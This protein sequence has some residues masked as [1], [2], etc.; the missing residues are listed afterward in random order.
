[1]ARDWSSSGTLEASKKSS[2]FQP[3]FDSTYADPDEAPD[4]GGEGVFTSKSKMRWKFRGPW[5]AGM[6]EAEL[7]TYI[8]KEVRHRKNDFREYVRAR[9]G[10]AKAHSQDEARREM[11]VHHG[12]SSASENLS[13][14]ELDD[15]IRRLR[16]DL[17]E[18]PL[19]IQ[20]FLDLPAISSENVADPESSPSEA[21]P[22]KTHPSAGLSYLR[23]NSFLENHPILGPQGQPTPVESRVLAPHKAAG[24]PPPL[25]VGG[26]VAKDAMHTGGE[27]RA[28]DSN[29]PFPRETKVWVQPLRAFINTRGMI[30]LTVGTASESAISIGKGQLE[31]IKTS[32]TPTTMPAQDRQDRGRQTRADLK[33]ASNLSNRAGAG[34][35]MNSIRKSGPQ[36]ADN[37]P[38][39]YKTMSEML[40]RMR[41][42]D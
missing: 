9:V 22:P 34:Y 7:H 33:L 20:I 13:D 16:Q 12:Q 18:L 1:M 32:S 28:G 25:G 14:A 4:A 38:M 39:V 15:H 2:V 19:L 40:T 31:D 23:S 24:P 10:R 29:K 35:V 26:V 5:L 42:A 30:K 8:N 41:P 27:F 17:S 11:G 37:K 3:A 21:G 36:T 6:T